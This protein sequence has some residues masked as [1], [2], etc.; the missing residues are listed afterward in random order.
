MPLFLIER[1]FSEVIEL[2]AVG[3]RAIA[4]INGD[5]G[6]NWLYSF[7]SADRKKTYCLYEGPSA[8]TIREAARRNNLPADAVIELAETLKPEAFLA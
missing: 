5:L 1:Q 2:D 6:V 4:E 3:V 8:E 7:L